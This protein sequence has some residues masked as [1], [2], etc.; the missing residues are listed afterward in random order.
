M[1]EFK[2][3][4]NIFSKTG[5]SELKQYLYNNGKIFLEVELYDN[6]I[7]SMEFETEILYCKNIDL[8][9]PFNIGY[10]DCIKLSDVLKVE[11]NHYSFSGNFIDLMK[12]QRS[13]FNLAFGLNVQYYTHII[14]F[15]NSSINLAF[16]VNEKDNYKIS[17]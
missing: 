11:N 9:T 5:D 6:D 17:I 2:T 7:L 14:I 4:Q 1:N 10:F 8:K 12:A 16:V 13:K 3:L 15:A